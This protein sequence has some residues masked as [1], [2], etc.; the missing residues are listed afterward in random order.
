M[1]PND[2]RVVTRQPECRN[3]HH[4]GEDVHLQYA[5]V[6]GVGYKDTGP[7]CDNIPDCWARWDKANACLKTN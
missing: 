2:K 3:C 1:T 6:G 7:F 4:K 5:Y